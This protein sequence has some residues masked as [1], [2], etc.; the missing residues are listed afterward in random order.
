MIKTMG[1]NWQQKKVIK[2]IK[3]K[4]K[5]NKKQKTNKKEGKVIF[6]MDFKE[7]V[8]TGILI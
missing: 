6:R 1:L 3:K 4:L 7:I 2:G 5:K 8:T